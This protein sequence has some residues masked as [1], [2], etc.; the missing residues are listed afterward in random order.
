M[1]FRIVNSDGFTV[2]HMPPNSV[3]TQKCVAYSLHGK[4]IRGGS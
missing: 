4:G 2:E 3:T 1:F